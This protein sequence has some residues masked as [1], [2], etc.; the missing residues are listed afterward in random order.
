MVSV[1]NDE[2]LE[3]RL[4]SVRDGYDKILKLCNEMDGLFHA[5]SVNVAIV[6]EIAGRWRARNDDLGQ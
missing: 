6:T 2:T 3:S 1:G 4:K 5:A